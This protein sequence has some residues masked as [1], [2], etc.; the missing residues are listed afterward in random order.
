MSELAIE[1]PHGSE[2]MGPGQVV[3]GD[4][5]T[6]YTA[7]RGAVL[8]GELKPGEVL[9]QLALSRR[10]GVGRT[11]LREASRRLQAEGLLRTER[12]RRIT[13]APLSLQEF[14]DL[15]T[16]RILTETIAIEMSVPRLSD[17]DLELISGSLSTLNEGLPEPDREAMRGFHDGLYSRASERLVEE[18]RR[19]GDHAD[20][21][22]TVYFADWTEKIRSLVHARHDHDEILQAAT[23]RDGRG[24]ALLNARHL[25]WTALTGIALLDVRHEPQQIRSVLDLLGVPGSG[26]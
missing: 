24:C 26:A 23:A 19:L 5:E 11:P 8:N 16:L 4:N 18:C 21:Y 1:L 12:N 6:A 3:E 15:Y 9:S 7:L 2:G 14:E 13:I 25:G 20:R 22:W 10:L 17:E